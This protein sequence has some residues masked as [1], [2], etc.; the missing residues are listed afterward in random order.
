MY[1][2]DE[3]TRVELLSP[4]VFETEV[5]PR[6]NVGPVPNGGYVLAL[7]LA[8]VRRVVTPPDPVT[9]TAHYLR[10]TLVGPASIEVTKIKEGRHATAMATLT[11]EGKERVRVLATYGDLSAAKGPE[12]IAATLPAVDPIVFGES[13]PPNPPFPVEIHKRFNVQMDK[14]DS[15][16]GARDCARLA[17]RIRFADGREPDIHSLALFSDSMPPPVF[18]VTPPGWVPTREL[19]V[20]FRARPKPGWL[21]AAF[22]TRFLF[23]GYLEE[24]GEMW[25]ESGHL[26]ALS[27]QFAGSP[28][29]V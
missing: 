24:D 11:Q 27:R 23:D 17:A 4:G 12:H 8:A 1:T 21:N 20:H 2:F 28:R 26:V 29:P 9:A 16:F 13:G 19:T 10:P 25:D 14:V 7:A 18:R 6:W 22:Q 5:T 3:D 15:P